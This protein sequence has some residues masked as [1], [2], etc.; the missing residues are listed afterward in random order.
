MIKMVKIQNHKLSI[1]LS[2]IITNKTFVFLTQ[3]SSN[4]LTKTTIKWNI[5][6]IIYIKNRTN[7][8]IQILKIFIINFFL[9]KMH[10]IYD[11]LK[12]LIKIH[13]SVWTNFKI[14]LNQISVKVDYH[15]LIIFAFIKR[16]KNFLKIK[17][18]LFHNI[19]IIFISYIGWIGKLIDL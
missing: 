12:K 15:T 14:I 1:F 5:I 13:F 2:L 6:I 4:I 18:L 17:I 7:G 3:L 16:I 10:L 11:F 9:L 8:I 19:N